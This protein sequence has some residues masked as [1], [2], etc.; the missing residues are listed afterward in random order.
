[1]L[2][3]EDNKLSF[4]V[5]HSASESISW[6]LKILAFCSFHRQHMAIPRKASHIDM[7]IGFLKDFGSHSFRVWAG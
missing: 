1:M 6:F 2:Q 4:I 3:M 7:I 5:F